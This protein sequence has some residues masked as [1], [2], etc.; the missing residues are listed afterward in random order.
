MTISAKGR[1]LLATAMTNQAEAKA[2]ADK[3]DGAASQQSL[4]AIEDLAADA[5]I[6]NRPVFAAPTAMTLESAAL[7]AQGAFAGIDA[8][9]TMVVTLK[10]GAGNTIVT[11]T[12]NNV[13]V[14]TNSGVNDLGT[15]DATQKILTANELVTLSIT[16]GATANPPAMLLRLTFGRTVTG[17]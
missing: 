17:G 13:T 4:I 7:I 3:I 15:L 11:K 2:L 1:R 5:D 10:D 16:N 9:N 14:P 8:G 6:A 12:Y